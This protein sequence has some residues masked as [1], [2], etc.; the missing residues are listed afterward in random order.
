MD[1]LN[2]VLLVLAFVAGAGVG[3]MGTYFT[4]GRPLVKLVHQMRIVGYD[5][6][7]R[8]RQEPEEEDLFSEFNET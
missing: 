7:R 2:W 1:V 8:I 3:G 4:V 5:P 6:V